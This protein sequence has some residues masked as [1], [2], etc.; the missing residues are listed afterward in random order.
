[1]PYN[2]ET[3]QVP[4]IDAEV[5]KAGWADDFFLIIPG[6]VFCRILLDSNEKQ[7]EEAIGQSQFCFKPCR[8]TVKAIFIVRQII[9]K[10]AKE[11]QVPP[12]L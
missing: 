6:K 4:D 9:K 5:I 1:M 11:H 3:L 10:K 2:N 12:T 8:G 7:T